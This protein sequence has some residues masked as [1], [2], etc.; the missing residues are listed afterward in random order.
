MDILI[1]F[2]PLYVD[3]IPSHLFRMLMTLEEYMKANRE[4]P[5]TV[6]AIIN[7]GFYEGKQN[8][9]A[10]QIL[11]NWCLRTGI[12]FGQGIGMGAGEMM[13]SLNNVPLGKGPLKNLG[14]AYQNM[15]D[16]IKSCNTGGSVFLNPNFPKFAWKFIACHLFWNQTARKN[17]L[18]KKDILRQL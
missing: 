5:I 15:A 8:H 17:G 3:G 2:F 14:Q 16:L 7:N 10:M 9:I 12:T 6:Y 11:E 1:F 18:E 13:D 4:S